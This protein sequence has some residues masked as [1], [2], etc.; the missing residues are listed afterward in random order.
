MLCS[1][2]ERSLLS[3]RTCVLRTCFLGDAAT[4]WGFAMTLETA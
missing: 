1:H 2:E 4:V 3:K